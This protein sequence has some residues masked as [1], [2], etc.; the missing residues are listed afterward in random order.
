MSGR[1]ELLRRFTPWWP[2]LAAIVVPA[3]LSFVYM[4]VVRYTELHGDEELVRALIASSGSLVLLF[5]PTNSF[6]R[7]L[8]VL[9]YWIVL[10]WSLPLICLLIV[11]S[12]FGDCL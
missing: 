1:S 12:F 6:L 9:I 7:I 11:C 10:F 8:S 3:V 5:L 2:L 4:A